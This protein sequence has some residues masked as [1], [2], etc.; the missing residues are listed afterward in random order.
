MEESDPDLW[1]RDVINPDFVQLHRLRQ[2][3]YSGKTAFQSVEVID[4]DGFGR[5]L[6][7]DG[8]IQSAE[9]DEFIYHE[10][11]VH[12]AMIGHLDPRTVFVAGGGEGATVREALRHRSVEKV[13]MVDIDKEA[14]DIC[15]R[16][17]PSMHRG[18][19][20]DRRTELLHLDAKEYLASSKQRFDVIIIDLTDPVEGGPS[21]MLYTQEFYRLVQE[22][23]SPTG[24]LVL[25]AGPCSLEELRIFVAINRTLQ[26]VFPSVSPYQAHIPSFG[27]LWG[28]AMASQ[29]SNPLSLSAEEVDRRIGARLSD[30]L[31]FYDG[32]THRGLFHPPLYLRHEL[33]RGKTIITNN[34]PLFIC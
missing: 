20:D 25:Q 26:S 29:Q 28:F 16:F 19:F 4:T 30:N 11:L 33:S 22:R 24:T 10:A 34:N 14:V 7:L 9:M 1:F 2:T 3:V 23:L 13:V 8:K 27:G 5:C 21:C 31:R 18:A 15:R 12:P 17:L 32:V 6:V